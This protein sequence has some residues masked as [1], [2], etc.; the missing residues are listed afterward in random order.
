MSECK[1]PGELIVHAE[2]YAHVLAYKE[3]DNRCSYCFKSC[4]TLKKCAACGLLKYCDVKC[5]KSDW[6]IHKTECPCYK[7]TLPKIPTDSVRLLLRIVIRHLRGDDEKLVPEDPGWRC[8]SE[9]ES[10]CLDIQRDKKRSDIFSQMMFTLQELVGDL[11]KLPSAY[12]LF[13]MFGKMVINT[14]SICDDSLQSIGSGLYVSPSQIDHSC[15]PNAVAIF[16]GKTVQIRAVAEIPDVAPEKLS[17]SYIDQLRPSAERID[18]LE[19]QYYFTC[20]CSRC[21]DKNIDEVMYSVKCPQE[22]CSGYLG[23]KSDDTF[24]SCSNCGDINTDQQYITQ[25][26]KTIE[27]V[28]ERLTKLEDIKKN[29]DWSGVLSICEECLKSFHILSEL[30]V[31][32]TRLLDL[33][34]DSC[35]NLELWQKALKYGLQTLE[36]YRY[37]YPV[38]TPNLSLQ[39]MK[40]GKIQLF[41]EKTEDSLKTLQEA[42][43]GLQISHGV[44][45]S[46]Y[47]ALLQLIAQ[48]TEELRHKIREQS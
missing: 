6:S 17:L 34:F 2:P 3:V 44:E 20:Q 12:L 1:K 24:K 39:L 48:G 42:E 29:G 26:L 4:T 38:N 16:S 8:F 41:L 47:Q 21:L 14:F 7:Q 19:E 15:Q 27:I 25:S 32:R 10:H 22:K 36:A 5:Q 30:N 13:S 9:L 28:D 35:I 43:T 11:I 31:Y 33:A 18:E 23:I 46:L 37:H 40:V 45:H